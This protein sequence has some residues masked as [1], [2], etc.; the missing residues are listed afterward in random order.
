MDDI[1]AWSPLDATKD[2]ILTRITTVVSPVF[3]DA[4]TH[5][6]LLCR[7]FTN[8]TVVAVSDGSYFADT[9]RAAAAWL[10][11]SE[12]RT[13]WIM[14]SVIVPGTAKDFNAYRSELTG[15]TVISLITKI[16]S[17][18]FPCPRHILIGCDGQAALQ[19]LTATRD[20]ITANSTNYDLHSTIVDI[21]SS[22]ATTPVPIHIKGHQ[23]LSGQ[24]LTRLEEM[25]IMMD[26]L[27]TMTARS[28]I[29]HGAQLTLPSI[30]L[31]KV[32]YKEAS[33]SGK[34]YKTLYHNITASR[35][36]DYYEYK[37]NFSPRVTT[38]ISFE[39]FGYTRTRCPQ[40]LNK[41]ISKWL[42]DTLATGMIMQRRQ[43]R[44][45]N[46]CPRCNTWGEDRTH[47]LICWD[48]RAKIIWDKNLLSLTNILHNSNTHPHII[49]LIMNGMAMF[50]R[51][52]HG[53]HIP[54]LREGW[55][56]EQ[57]NIGWRNFLSGFIGTSMISKQQEHYKTLGLRN[58]GKQWASKIILHNWS[59]IQKMW[60]GRNT[61]LHQ[62]ETINSLSGE[63]LLDI[64]IEKEY[65]LGYEELPPVV[66]KW[67]N[68]T[69]EQLLAQST[70]YKKGWL[71]II[72]TVKESLHIADYSLF[73]TSR[74]LRKWIR[75]A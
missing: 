12:C 15:L 16:L 73:T 39:A 22:L 7:D 56:Q 51:H 47:V 60:F 8:G 38:T 30:G 21:W 5:L 49:E 19:A 72:K 11:E 65:D 27:A 33:I 17:C 28:T 54:A 46:R 31:R 10:I 37:H 69:K 35:L 20:D 68:I 45:F 50:R 70:D 66:H 4:S 71:L 24:P 29:I 26:K 3:L 75:M 57:W 23:D 67:F 6:E 58:K 14:G 41:F 62:K 1:S 55:Q 53:D 34:L 59:M 2:S 40:N 74:A 13:Q 64:D 18:C 25:N 32:S 43:Q 52:P 48:V 36:V 61:V 9:N 42:S 44:V 63:V